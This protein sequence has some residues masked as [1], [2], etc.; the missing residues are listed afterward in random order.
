MEHDKIPIEEGDVHRELQS[1][2]VHPARVRQQH[3]PLDFRAAKQT[4]AAGE[5]RIGD[6]EA[7]Q[8]LTVTQQPRHRTR[9]L[10]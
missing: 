9:I 8:H 2:G 7:R 3:R 6:L 4:T 1:D 5:E 10:A